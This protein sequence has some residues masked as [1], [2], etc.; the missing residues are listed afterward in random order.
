ML[1]SIFSDMT[2]LQT[3]RTWAQFDHKGFTAME[4]SITR[5]GRAAFS[6]SSRDSEAE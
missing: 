6:E 3:T 4:N 5:Y 2:N 1:R